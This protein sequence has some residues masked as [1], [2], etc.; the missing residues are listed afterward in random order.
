MVTDPSRQL[1][2]DADDDKPL[3]P[4]ILAWITAQYRDAGRVR[5]F[6]HVPPPIIRHDESGY[7]LVLVGSRL[8][9]GKNWRTF[10]D[11]L[12]RYVQLVLGRDWCSS[13]RAKAP[14]AQHPV[15]KWEREV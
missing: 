2:D 14:A 15:I 8:C 5:K 13:E 12:H 9:R 11:F 7:G 3:P 6:G 4:E 1:D 10:P